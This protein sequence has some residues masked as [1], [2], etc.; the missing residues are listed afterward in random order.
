MNHD[1]AAS[2]V[3]TITTPDGFVI[4]PDWLYKGRARLDA[5]GVHVP[6]DAT[7]HA[8]VYDP[9]T[10]LVEAINAP[11]FDERLAHDEATA[12]AAALSF[13]GSSAWG[14]GTPHECLHSVDYGFD[15]P[16]I[17]PFLYPDAVAA[18]YWTNQQTK[19]TE[20]ETGSARSFFYVLM[21]YGLVSS[22]SASSRLR[23][24]PVRRAAP[25][26]QCLVIGQ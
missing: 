4:R 13:A 26:S 21:N 22:A 12:A 9:L 3:T 24:R 14:I 25:A 10:G 16:S 7:G 8:Q 15:D 6:P 20:G 1:L 11:G 19:W 23:A 5:N 17:D 18:G 2:T